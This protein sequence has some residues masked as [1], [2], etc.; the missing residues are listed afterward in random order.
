MRDIVPKE[1][2]YLAEVGY[3]KCLLRQHR[4]SYVNERLSN[5]KYKLSRQMWLIYAQAQRKLGDHESATYGI[6]QAMK[7]KTVHMINPDFQREDKTIKL[8]NERMTVTKVL[9]LSTSFPARN[10]ERSF[11]NI[12]SVDGGGIRGIIPAIWLMAL[13][14][15]I[16]RPVS[17]IFD[18][19][20]G[21]STGAIISAG[22]TTPS[23]DNPSKP[24]YQASD[25]VQLYQKKAD[26]VFTKNSN[27]VSQLRTLVLKEPKYLDKAD[28]HYSVT[29][30]VEPK[31]LILSVNY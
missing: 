29:T 3:C 5:Y 11:Y 4:Y 17:S 26:E 19:V 10:K 31:L 20:A 28:I 13:E 14:E 23:L 27:F 9:D 8:K 24:R 16:K 2:L 25:L 30:S 15:K 6:Q 18:V 7:S 12:L 1:Q 22:L 21:T